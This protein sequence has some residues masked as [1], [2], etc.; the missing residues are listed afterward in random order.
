MIQPTQRDWYYNVSTKA[1]WGCTTCRT[2]KYLKLNETA[3]K[4][5]KELALNLTKIKTLSF[6]T[7]LKPIENCDVLPL[8][9]FILSRGQKFPKTFS[10]ANLRL[11]RQLTDV[12]STVLKLMIKFNKLERSRMSESY[13]K[14][15]FVFFAWNPVFILFTL[16]PW[17]TAN[18][19]KRLSRS[20]NFRYLLR[21]S[22]IRNVK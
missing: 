7:L 19:V 6:V 14:F 17:T 8:N 13:L 11:S 12:V 18:L 21:E 3:F 10:F 4:Q 15:H 16:T 5:E 22:P 20:G 1:H 9:L 2:A